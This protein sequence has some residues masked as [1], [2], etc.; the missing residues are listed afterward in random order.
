MCS[1]SALCRGIALGLLESFDGRWVDADSPSPPR[2]PVGYKLL[3]GSINVQFFELR[4]APGVSTGRALNQAGLAGVE[5]LAADLPGQLGSLAVPIVPEG[6][7]IVV[8]HRDPAS[9]E[10]QG[11]R[12]EEHT[13][14]LQSQR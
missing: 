6:L 3:A 1:I 10:R 9:E 14:E 2:Q 13:S 12:S 8:Q 4:H 5:H 7:S 11:F